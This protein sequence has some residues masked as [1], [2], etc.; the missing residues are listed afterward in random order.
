MMQKSVLTHLLNIGKTYGQG[1][2]EDTGF[3]TRFLF[4]SPKSLM[5]SREYVEAQ[6]ILLQ[7][8]ITEYE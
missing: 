7:W 3:V 1:W 6:K 2:A 8:M 5:G 4:A